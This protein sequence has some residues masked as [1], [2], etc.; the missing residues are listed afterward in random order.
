MSVYN[1]QRFSG[2]C[3]TAAPEGLVPARIVPP[4]QSMGFRTSGGPGICIFNKFSVDTDVVALGN[5][6][7]RTTVLG[8][9]K[10]PRSKECSLWGHTVIP[11]H[12]S[13]AWK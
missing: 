5:H 8:L 6:T 13:P 9:C 11:P 7:L 10:G 1:S 2:A 12:R 4:P 3:I